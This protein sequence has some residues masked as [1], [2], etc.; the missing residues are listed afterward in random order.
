MRQAP[1]GNQSRVHVR[2]TG[3]LASASCA[4]KAGSTVD[5][6][7]KVVCAACGGVGADLGHLALINPDLS[8]EPLEQQ[9]PV[10]PKL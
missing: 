8:A 1:G 7:A 10:V 5:S 3:H 4:H 6:H 2:M 9:L